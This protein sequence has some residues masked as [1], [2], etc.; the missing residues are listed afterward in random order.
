MLWTCIFA[1]PIGTVVAGILLCLV[2]TRTYQ[3]PIC[4]RTCTLGL[5]DLII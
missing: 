3:P 1:V 4:Y 2:L 5:A